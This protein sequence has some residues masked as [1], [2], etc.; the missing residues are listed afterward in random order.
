[1]IIIKLHFILN[2]SE[3]M[4]RET[5]RDEVERMRHNR[6]EIIGLVNGTFCGW[7]K[8]NVHIITENNYWRV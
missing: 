4:K 8:D 3:L 6:T 5:C 2:M 7:T 1:M